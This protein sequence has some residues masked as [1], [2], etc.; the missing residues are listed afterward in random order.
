[1]KKP[2]LKTAMFLLIIS[3]LFAAP[4]CSEQNNKLNEDPYHWPSDPEVSAKLE[5]WQDWKFGVIIH[6]GPYSE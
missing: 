1:M 6:W 5:A 4:G 3:M 2:M